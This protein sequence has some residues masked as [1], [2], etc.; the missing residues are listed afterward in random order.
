LTDAHI[1]HLPP[2]LD[3]ENAVGHEKYDPAYVL[4]R[5]PDLIEIGV[6]RAGVPI[7]AGFAAYA[8]R[9]AECYRLAV[10]V[11]NRGGPAADG[12]FLL[13]TGTWSPQRF[14][15]GYEIAVYARRLGLRARRHC[16]S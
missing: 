5:R 12:S 11:K 13:E 16:D 6:N 7:T 10:L 14:D 4:A 3:R 8:R 2:R 15:E 1:A 9:I